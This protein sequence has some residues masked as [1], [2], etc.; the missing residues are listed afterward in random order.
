L[1]IPSQSDTTIDTTTPL[2]NKIE[3]QG[4]TV[5]VVMKLE[6]EKPNQI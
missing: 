2:F 6:F 5:G 1:H 3:K 4:A